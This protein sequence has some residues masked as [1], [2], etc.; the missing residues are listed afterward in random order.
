LTPAAQRL[1]SRQE[2]DMIHYLRT[3]GP[4]ILGM[5]ACFTAA[6]IALLLVLGATGSAPFIYSAF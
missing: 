2:V 4:F 1:R 6:L 5:A 3:W